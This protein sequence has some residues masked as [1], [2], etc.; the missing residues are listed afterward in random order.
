[1]H[2]TGL[3]LVMLMFCLANAGLV[4]AGP[5]VQLIISQ[6]PGD[7]KG[8]DVRNIFTLTAQDKNNDPALTRPYIVLFYV[9]GLL[10]QSL[11]GQTLPASITR[12]F[13]GLVPGA[14][15][16][17]ADIED[18]SDNGQV[19]AKAKATITVKKR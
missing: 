12:N 13:S 14:H 7:D 16:I 11:R 15:E 6:A 9:D 19:L 3:V 18:N 1:M 10:L 8:T 2:K 5:N 17:R 4:W